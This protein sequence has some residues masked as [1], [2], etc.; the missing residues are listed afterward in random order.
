MKEFKVSLKIKPNA[1]EFDYF[2]NKTDT[3]ISNMIRAARSHYWDI[4]DKI[5]NISHKDFGPVLVH[6]EVNLLHPIKNDEEVIVYKR[7]EDIGTTSINTTYH[8]CNSQGKL[9]VISKE[10]SV[11]YDFKLNQK[12][13]VPM[14]L[15]QRIRLVEEG[16]IK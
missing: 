10:D 9:C 4:L 3:A 5:G 12:I 8:I 2:G 14:E 13:P 6:Y 1:T 11:F 7:V 16:K 15:K